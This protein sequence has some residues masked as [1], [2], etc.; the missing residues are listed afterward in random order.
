M[1]ER[2]RNILRAQLSRNR[3]RFAMKLQRG[4]LALRAHHF[5]ITPA[6]AAT[7]SR[8]QRL[9]PG[10]LRSEARGISFTAV[11]LPLAITDFA[12]SEDALQETVAKPFDAIAYAG[13][14]GD[15]YSRANDHLDIVDR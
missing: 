5:D 2:K 1:S 14:F 8:A 15:V 3:R 7:P 11:G 10:F 13:H 4:T 6:D 9:H 12:G